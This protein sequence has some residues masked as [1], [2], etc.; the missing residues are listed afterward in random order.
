MA[1]EDAPPAEAPPPAEGVAAKASPVEAIIKKEAEDVTA[2]DQSRMLNYLRYKTS[3][4]GNK[5][6]TEREEAQEALSLYYSLSVQEKNKFVADFTSSGLSKKSGNWKW[7]TT[8]KKSMSQTLEETNEFHENW[9]TGPQIL[10]K[11][12][13]RW[14]DIP[15]PAERAAIIMDLV[16]QSAKE[17]GHDIQIR[18]NTTHPILT[19]YWYLEDR[20]RRIASIKRKAEELVSTAND[21][22]TLQTA[23]AA[24]D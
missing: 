10:E 12:G 11:A 19:K 2:N 21:A 20:G 14:A 7:M 6:G 23:F 9:C 13:L 1:L 8:F 4:T 16:E 3:P 15:D 5:K 17:F 24:G 18:E 22:K